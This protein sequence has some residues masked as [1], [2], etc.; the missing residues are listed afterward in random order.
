MGGSQSTPTITNV[1]KE[2]PYPATTGADGISLSQAEKCNGCRLAVDTKITTS[3]V[4]LKRGIGAISSTQC[5]LYEQD[6]ARVNSKYMSVA[7]FLAKLQLGSYS[8]PVSE[9]PAGADG[10]G[11]EQYCQ[12]LTVSET[13][14]AA[15]RE[16][17]KLDP[18]KFKRGRIRKV[19]GSSFSEETKAKFIPSIPFKMSFEARKAAVDSKGK[20]V[21]L[22]VNETFSVTQMTLYHPSPVRIDSVQADAMLSLNDPTDANATYIVLVPLKAVNSGNPSNT[23]FNKIARALTSIKEPNAGTGEYQDTTIQTGAD[24]SL[25]KLFTLTGD[26]GSSKVKNGFFTWTGVAGYERVNKGTV[27]SGNTNITTFGWQQTEGLKAPQYILLDTALDINHDDMA[28]L[29]L[30]LPVTPPTEAIHPIPAQ[31]FLVYHKASEPPAPDTLSGKQ[32]CGTGNLCEGFT[33]GIAREGFEGCPGARCDPFLQNAATLSNTDSVFTPQRMF[34]LFFGFLMTV[35]MFLG[36]YLALSMIKDNYDLSLRNFA[37]Q[38]GQV[39]AV[40]AKGVSD[41]TKALGSVISSGTSL[42]QGKENALENLSSAFKAKGEGLAKSLEGKGEDS[43]KELAGK[44]EE[45]LKSFTNGKEVSSLVGNI[46]SK[47][48]STA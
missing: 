22:P 10:K 46:T 3:N 37:E 36:A 16:N 35:A 48:K 42:L 27:R 21:Y 1:V 18:A 11:G 25:D 2:E 9:K 26:S 14:A 30:S 17:E 29:T 19:S 6:L 13:D 7:D 12:D 45:A 20:T 38:A 32:S 28:L 43:L 4:K 24:W 8:T 33:T 44:G 31:T 34:A 40:W 39:L 5:K 15:M 41:K 23:F 47:L